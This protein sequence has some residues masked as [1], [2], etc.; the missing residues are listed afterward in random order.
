[1]V[2]NYNHGI[3]EVF[4]NGELV[5]ANQVVPYR[6]NDSIMLGSDDNINGTIGN[7][8]YFPDSITREQVVTL[9]D[10]F[11]NKNPPIL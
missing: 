6:S 11:K 9:Y 7:V 3:L 2:I 4:Y 5:R 1:M 10:A 8:A